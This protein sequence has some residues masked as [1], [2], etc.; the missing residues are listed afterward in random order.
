MGR[1]S[2]GPEIA[3][4]PGG[5]CSNKQGKDMRLVR[6]GSGGWVGGKERSRE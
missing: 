5:V 6:V 1:N 3:G 4:G 2:P